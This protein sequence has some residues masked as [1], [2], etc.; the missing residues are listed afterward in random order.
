MRRLSAALLVLAC[1]AAAAA[2]PPAKNGEIAGVASVV[3]GDTLEIHGQRIRL[4][5]IDTPESRQSC[6]THEGRAWP[7]GRQAAFAVD[8]AVRGKTVRCKVKDVDRY[9]RLVAVCYVGNDDLNAWI[10]RSGWA[11]AYQRYSKD[12]VPHEQAARAEQRNIWSGT[13]ENP[14]DYRRK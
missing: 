11:F 2:A 8:E 5:G 10:V 13:V 3:D 12:Y 6:F 9:Q 4:F 14:A 7:C 1:G